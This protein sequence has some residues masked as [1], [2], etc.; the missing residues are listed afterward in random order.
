MVSK[1]HKPAAAQ[2]LVDVA[3]LER[4]YY[5]R[6]PEPR[7]PSQM[8]SFGTSGH[9]GTSLRGTFTE[10]HILAIAQAIC[11]YR[12]SR[13]ITRAALST[14]GRAKA[15]SCYETRQLLSLILFSLFRVWA[16]AGST[17]S[18]TAA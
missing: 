7:N 12:R 16:E 9:R 10:A 11:D 5:Q 17:G 6:R 2:M 14:Y 15:D 1:T 18:P 8:V 13:G 3:R 4:E